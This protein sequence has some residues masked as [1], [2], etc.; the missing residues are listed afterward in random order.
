MS[1]AWLSHL[2]RVDISKGGV[3]ESGTHI[4]T[5]ISIYRWYYEMVLSNHLD[6]RCVIVFVLF[7]DTKGR[8]MPLDL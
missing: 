6:L 7:L 2:I 3:G 5:H 1:L 8:G 4:S